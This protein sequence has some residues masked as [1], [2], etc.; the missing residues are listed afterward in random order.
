MI[1]YFGMLV[2]NGGYG[3]AFSAGVKEASHPLQSS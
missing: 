3:G 1:G 2:L